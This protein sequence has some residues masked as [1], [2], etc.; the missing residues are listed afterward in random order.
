MTT[1]RVRL[2][3][4]VPVAARDLEERQSFLCP[5]SYTWMIV[6]FTGCEVDD[7]DAWVGPSL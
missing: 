4:A 7:G 2:R 1:M 3:S 6:S 5:S